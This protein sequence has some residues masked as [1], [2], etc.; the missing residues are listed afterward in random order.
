MVALHDVVLCG[1]RIQ[2]EIAIDVLP[3]WAGPADASVDVTIRLG[4]VPALDVGGPVYVGVMEDESA[5]VIAQGVGRFRVSSGTTV[6]AQP[7][8]GVHP[9][10]IEMIIIGPVFGALCYQ[11]NI[12]ALHCNT[13]VINGK[14]VALAGPSGAGKSTLA[15]VLAG[16]G[17]SLIADDVLAITPEPKGPQGVQGMVAHTGNRFLRLLPQTL[18]LLGRDPSGLRRASTGERDK[19]FL[20]PPP[21]ADILPSYPLA[22][23]VWLA[24]TPAKVEKISYIKGM[25]EK[26]Q[27]I[28]IA[29]YRGYL[30]REY[31]R[32]G[33]SALG[34][35]SLPGVDF[36][37][38]IRPRD[39][40][41]LDR[42]ADMI[43]ALV[44]G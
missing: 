28:Q 14:A 2:S 3:P 41:R 8:A 29:T 1:L 15:A 27:G 19:Y 20:P 17:H 37:V 23:L 24:A 6:I 35:M 43:E 16:R 11:R 18:E 32:R 5:I 25:V 21:D 42:Q 26:A 7:E 34:D 22:A 4:E 44:A 38:M 31:I 40:T 12:Q 30:A 9:G 10:A 39:L 33:R 13:V 36:Y